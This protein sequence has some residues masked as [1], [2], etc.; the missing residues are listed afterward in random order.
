MKMVTAAASANEASRD[1]SSANAFDGRLKRVRRPLE[2]EIADQG[3]ERRGRKESEHRELRKNRRRQRRAE[4]GGP[5]PGRLLQ[6]QQH[7]EESGSE[8]R[9]QGHVGGCE[10]RVRQ[11][12]GQEREAKRRE[13]RRRIAEAAARPV[14][15]DKCPEPEEWQNSQTR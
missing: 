11:N 7:R 2:Y 10:S 8:R 1:F 4:Q 5:S 15:H 6:P 14:I 3:N 9:S 12:R 13:E